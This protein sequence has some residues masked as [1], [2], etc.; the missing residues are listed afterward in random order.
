MLED[1][2]GKRALRRI[3][4]GVDGVVAVSDYCG[5]LAMKGGAPKSKVHVV[6]N[7]TDPDAYSPAKGPART[8]DIL[9]VCRL[10][11]RKDIPTLLK[12]LKM[13]RKK[14]PDARLVVVGDGPEK[15]N[16]QKMAGSMGLGKSVRF[17]GFTPEEELMELY[18][19]CAVFVLPARYDAE[20]RDIEGFGIVLLE[21]MASGR[22]VIGADV[23][24][25]PSAV[26][27]GWGYLYE[28][29]DWK[30][31]GNRIIYLM[32]HPAQARRM[33]RNGRRA[34][35]EIY[36]WDRNASEVV[37]VYDSAR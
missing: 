33:G 25:I 19:R 15:E 24:G 23:G 17:M 31:L 5:E 7:A 22:P 30:G 20:G 37:K 8:A 3:F 12:A 36:N 21:A 11:P 6:Y 9:A 27:E 4:K 10:V 35:E 13:T 26:R 34:V 28:P 18:S 32:E 14:V 29:G 2:F 1:W 16:L